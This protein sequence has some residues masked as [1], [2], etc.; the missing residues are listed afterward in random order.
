MNAQ[1]SIGL[2]VGQDFD[3]SVAV[4]QRAGTAVG[5]KREDSLA[6]LDAFRLQLVFGFADAG[7]FGMRVGDGGNHV[8]VDVSVAGHEPLDAGHG[9][10]LGLMGEHRTAN[11]VPHG[12]NARDDRV[13]ML[14]DRNATAIQ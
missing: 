1:D 7:H 8:V 11:D 3:E 4:A 10:V 9:L 2:G 14:V 13:E 6:V 5:T 12:E